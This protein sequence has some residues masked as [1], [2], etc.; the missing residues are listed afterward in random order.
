MN[1]NNGITLIALVITI[2]VLLILAG[3]AI[4]MLSG[5]NG[6]LKKAGEA[7]IKTEEAQKEEST[8]LLDM[9]I[10]GY[11][12]EKGSK[13]KCRYG[14]ITGVGT[15]EIGGLNVLDHISDLQSDLPDGYKV[16]YQYDIKEKKDVQIKVSEEEKNNIPLKTGMG[17]EKDGKIVARVVVFGDIDCSGEIT[18]SDGSDI[19]CQV[20]GTHVLTEGFCIAAMD[21]NHDGYIG[22]I[23]YQ[24]VLDATV[25]KCNLS[26][27]QKNAAIDP[28][29]LNSKK[30]GEI[31]K[32]YVD[33]LQ[34]QDT[35]YKWMYDTESDTIWLEVPTLE[36]TGNDLISGLG[37]SGKALI[38]RKEGRK[39]IE[40]STEKIQEGDKIVLIEPYCA[41]GSEITLLGEVYLEE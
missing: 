23:D 19:L 25:G 11:F 1:K 37:L 34:L 2:I 38:K 21:L 8:T 29:K 40:I 12:K 39:D 22:N 27:C 5:E 24:M 14:Y 36:I 28:K 33:K 6:I 9:E 17:I 26:D 16:S 10:D 15:D 13:Y 41:Y 18:V 35:S 7:K 3:V 4:S 20:T 32:E 31:K 30:E